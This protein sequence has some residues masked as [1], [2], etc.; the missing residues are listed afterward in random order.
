MAHTAEP[1]AIFGTKSNKNGF[2]IPTKE[3]VMKH[4]GLTLLELLVTLALFCIILAVGIPSFNKQISDTHTK[5]A[6]LALLGAI[7][8][9][10]ATAVFHN[11]QVILKANNKKWH[12]GW[13]LFVDNNNNEVMD[14]DDKIINVHEG[15]DTVISTA[16]SPMNR[17]VAFIGT[18]EGRQLTTRGFLSG[19][20]KICP[21]AQ[22]EGYKLV[23]SKGGRTRVE[24]LSSTECNNVRQP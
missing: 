6:T 14:E 11:K 19:N 20:I 17:Y 3:H 7:E 4:S 22:G 16:S 9:T 15:L 10:R 5:T 21:Q 18:G 12:Q 1:T 8:T 13:T 23:L 24:K 2:R